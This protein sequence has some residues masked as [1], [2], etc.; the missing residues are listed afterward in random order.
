MC[1]E[2]RLFQ[3]GFLEILGAVSAIPMA[4][5]P[6]SREFQS[7]DDAA[8]SVLGKSCSALAPQPSHLMGTRQGFVEKK[9]L[10]EPGTPSSG[11]DKAVCYKCTADCW[12]FASIKINT[13]CKMRK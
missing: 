2:T 11:T 13:I 3:V 12:L 10:R 9:G 8:D 7:R 5:E 6:I 1:F 4:A